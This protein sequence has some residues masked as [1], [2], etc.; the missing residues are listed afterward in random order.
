[1]RYENEPCCGCGQALVPETED[2]VVCPDCGA[3]MHRHCWHAADG[4]PLAR[5][6]ND[7]FVWAPTVVPEETAEADAAAQP[8]DPKTQLGVI[9]PTCGENCPPDSRRCEACGAEFELNARSVLARVEQEHLRREQYMRENFPTY[10]VNGRE[11]RMGDAVAGQPM[12]EIVLQLRGSPRSVA[13]YL[14]RFEKDG[15][16]GW[17]WAAFFFGP[18]W[19]FFRKLYKPALMFAGILFVLTLAFAPMSNAMFRDVPETASVL[20]FSQAF[21]ASFTSYFLQHPWQVAVSG[22]LVLAT[23][24]AGA[25]FAGPLLRRKL[26]SNIVRASEDSADTPSQRFGRHQMLIRLGGIS[27]IAPMLYFL[28]EQFLPGLIVDIITKIAG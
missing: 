26:F 28:A 27:F 7:G 23:H 2:V 25:L 3:P 11:V 17:N 8:F 24:V 12:E 20:E 4:C 19:Y 14:S 13:H 15:R 16:V 6:H 10:T 5:Q 22:V 9:C 1:M 18:Y 21:Y